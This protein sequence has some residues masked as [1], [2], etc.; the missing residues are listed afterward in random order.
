MININHPDEIVKIRDL[1]KP[2][3]IAQVFRMLQAFGYGYA[4]KHKG[5]T[6]KIGHSYDNSKMWGERAYRQ[7]ANL[8]G[9]AVIPASSCGKDIISAVKAF[10]QKMDTV[11][12]KDDCTLEIWVCSGQASSTIEDEL[13]N[14]FFEM[15]GRLPPG[16]IKDTRRSKVSDAILSKFFVE[17]A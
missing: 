2:S 12:H 11:V 17:V 6:I 8:P 9:W 13:L 7:I 10:E 3:D 16:N 1:R 15:Y 14:Q 5:I 4:F